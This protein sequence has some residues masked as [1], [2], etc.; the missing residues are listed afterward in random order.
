MPFVA[1]KIILKSGLVLEICCRKSETK[2][3]FRTIVD[4]AVELTVG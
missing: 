4:R 2:L 1:F 3:S